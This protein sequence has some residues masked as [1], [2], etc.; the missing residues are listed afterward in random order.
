MATN[1]MFDLFVMILAVGHGH[2]PGS[3]SMGT[4]WSGPVQGDVCVLV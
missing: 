1:L 4:L 2:L 3:V